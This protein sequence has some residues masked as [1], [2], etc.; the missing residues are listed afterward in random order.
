M[1]ELHP[2]F[3]TDAHGKRLSVLLPIA[4]YEAMLELLED[5]QD[6]EDVQHLLAR[7]EQGDEELVP[8]ENVKAANGL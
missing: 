1:T 2:H 3:V 5:W 8:W 7:I 6:R 4:E